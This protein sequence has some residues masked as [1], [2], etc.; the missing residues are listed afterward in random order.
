PGP[1]RADAD[2]LRGVL[3]RLARVGQRLVHALRELAGELEGLR[4][5]HRA[6]L[7][8]HSLLDRPRGGEQAAVAVELAVEVDRALVEERPQHVMGLAEPGERARGAVSGPVLL[9][10]PEVPDRVAE[11]D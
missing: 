2:V 9:E 7:D 6:D 5:A 3:H 10:H 1:L 4:T 11:L 8:R